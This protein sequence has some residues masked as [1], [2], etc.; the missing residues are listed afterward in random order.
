MD[1]DTQFRTVLIFIAILVEVGVAP[2]LLPLV[3]VVSDLVRVDV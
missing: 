3:L 1:P 2:D